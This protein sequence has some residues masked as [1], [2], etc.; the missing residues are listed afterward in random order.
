MNTA[1]VLID[2]QQDYF[3][4]GRMEVA[5]SIEVSQAARKLLDYF[6][7]HDLPVIHIQHISTRKGAT[8]F[9]PDTEGI[10]FHENVLPLSNEVIIRKHFPNSF[11]DTTL[12]GYLQAN[13]IKELYICGMMSHM[14]ID[15][16]VRAAFDKGYTC[17]IVHDACAT[18]DLTFQGRNIPANNVHGSYMAALG[19]VYSKVLSVDEAIGILNN[20]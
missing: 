12:N 20:T 13:E 3:P 15:A 8:F 18:R 19:A 11:R 2:I 9:L 4:G 1:L 5:G 17:A 10:N 16:T 7:D 14:C 6:R